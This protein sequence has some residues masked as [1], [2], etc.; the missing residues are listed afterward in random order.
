MLPAKA[1]TF[2][3]PSEWIRA[4]S[5]EDFS[6]TAFAKGWRV[7][8]V[9]CGFGKNLEKL[10][11][12]G[13]EAEGI[14][15]DLEGLDYCRALG[16]H[17]NSGTAE[18]IECADE[19]FDGV[20]LDGVLAFTQPHLA[21]AEARRVLKPGGRLLMM[22]MSVGYGL[23]TMLARPGRA[24]LF[25][26]RMMASQPWFSL[27]GGRLGD[28]VCFSKSKLAALCEE[29]GFEIVR[30]EEGRRHFGLSVFLYVEARRN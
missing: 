23:Y 28:T 18:R 19:S 8:D 5:R 26:A 17:V 11:E 27:T 13:I 7:L 16:F 14:E 9:G 29:A 24:R 12:A 10:R 20:I 25:G 30:L 21:L 2:S 3:Q 22:T 6:M 1:I 4:H 15:P